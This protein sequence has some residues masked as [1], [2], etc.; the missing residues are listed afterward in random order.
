M[1]ASMLADDGERIYTDDFSVWE[2]ELNLLFSF[3][4]FL[5]LVVSRVNHGSIQDE[6]VG[7]GSWQ[8]IAIIIDCVWH[9]QFQQSVRITFEGEELLELGFECLEI[10]ILFILRIVAPYI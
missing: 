8:S 6:E 1:D 5:R 2:G 4:V 10:L 3:L 7:V 9:W